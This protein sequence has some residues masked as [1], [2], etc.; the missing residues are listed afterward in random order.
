MITAYQIIKDLKYKHVRRDR[1]II[2][3]RIL[4]AYKQVSGGVSPENKV[5][6]KEGTQE[7]SVF[8]YPNEFKIVMENVVHQYFKENPVVQKKAINKTIKSNA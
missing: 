7:F 5:P 8:A 4:E 6:Q 1:S 3:H 2:G